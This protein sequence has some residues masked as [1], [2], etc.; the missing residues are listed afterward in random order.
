MCHG[1]TS[2]THARDGRIVAREV[3]CLVALV[4]LMA[5]PLD[6]LE[7]LHLPLPPPVQGA[8]TAG[9][10]NFQFT[11][12]DHLRLS[13]ANSLTGVRVG[14][15]YRTA[16]TPTTTQPHRQD[17][18]PTADRAVTTMEFDV[19]PGYLL[20]V[21][22]FASSG[23]PKRGQT[24]AKLEVIRGF[25]AS[26]IVLGCVCAGYVT[27][28]QPI[29]WPGSPMESS[30][31]GDGYIRSVL[32]TQPAAGADISETVPTGARWELLSFYAPLTATAAA[33]NRTTQ[34]TAYT[35]GS[36]TK[37]FVPMASAQ[38][39]STTYSYDWAPIGVAVSNG[40]DRFV[41]PWSTGLGLAAGDTLQTGTGNLAA[42]DQW[43]RP[44]YGVR[45]WLE[46]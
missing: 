28:T 17:F 40:L 5:D 2:V 19:G 42:G 29:A 31:D 20:N 3:L 4:A 25:G 1:L 32:G 8:L 18:A 6:A 44:S 30:L 10:F 38:P 45:E 13:V 11:G 22:C 33:G 23:A 36:A 41:A 26:A 9:P 39:P 16:P 24:Y 27:A 14:V 7:E 34:L 21:V 46:I 37:L 35:S 43:G 12:E 15:H